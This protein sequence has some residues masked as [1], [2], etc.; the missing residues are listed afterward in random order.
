LAK[1]REKI[2]IEKKNGGSMKKMIVSLMLIISMFAFAAESAPSSTVGYVKYTNVLNASTTDLN[3]IA[4]PLVNSWTMSNNIDPTST[5]INSVQKWNPATQ[6]YAISNY[7]LGSWKNTFAIAPGNV[8]QVN[9]KS[10]HDIIVAGSLS[11][12]QYSLVTTA[13]TDL[14]HIMVPLSKASLSTTALL[15]ADIGSSTYTNS[16]QKWNNVTQA[17]AISNYSLG[18]WKNVYNTYIADPLQINVTN[19]KTWPTVAGKDEE[20]TGYD[21]TENSAPK[22]GL[23]RTVYVLIQDGSGNWYNY[24]ADC[25]TKVTWKAYVA[26]RPTDLLYWNTCTYSF[27]DNGL[28]GRVNT[29]ININEFAGTWAPG[30]VLHWIIKDETTNTENYLDIPLD[31][32]TDPYL[33]G[34]DTTYGVG[35]DGPSAPTHTPTLLSIPSSIE[36]NIPVTTALHQNY[37][38]PFNPTTAIKFDLATAGNVKLNVYNYNGQLVKSLVNGTM[39]AGYHTVNFDAANLAAGVYYYTMET[40]GKAMTQKMVLVK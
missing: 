29:A 10:N 28:D 31:N 17:Y 9:A 30:D 5:Y 27:E 1:L 15:G 2:T 8:L 25:G 36:G 34:F 7:S 37:P 12:V 14:N 24:P 21:A 38:N 22:G 32:S 3:H 19:A 40:A 33:V 4:L 11:S 18:S 39:N 26:A 23:A 13:G 16:I 20:V 35:A 6:A